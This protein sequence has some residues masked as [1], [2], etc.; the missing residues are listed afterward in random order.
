MVLSTSSR[1]YEPWKSPPID[2]HLDI[3]FFN[4]TNAEDFTKN[5]SAKPMFT[6]LG[7]YRFK[8]IPDKVDMKWNAH[9]STVT[10]RKK[11]LFFFDAEGSN[12]T[13]DDVITSVNVV[14]LVSF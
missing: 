14:A 13:L 6:E 11:S 1:S 9:N 3:Y 12:G 7:P 4:W 10:Y 8:E 2:L 5:T